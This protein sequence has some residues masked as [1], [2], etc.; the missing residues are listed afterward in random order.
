MF[1]INNQ[2]T[3][4]RLKSGKL[5]K[6]EV[7]KNYLASKWTRSESLVILQNLFN[8]F[9]NKYLILIYA[10]ARKSKWFDNVIEAAKLLK[11]YPIKFIFIGDGPERF[12]LMGKHLKMLFSKILFLKL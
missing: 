7:Q 9:N 4:I 12:D 2:I 3:V 11:N 1:F 5:R 10:G 8:K 6:K